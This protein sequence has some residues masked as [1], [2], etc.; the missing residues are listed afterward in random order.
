MEEMEDLPP[1][2]KAKKIGQIGP[3]KVEIKK[4]SKEELSR[5]AFEYKDVSSDEGQHY[6]Y[7]EDE[8]DPMAGLGDQM[9][10]DMEEAL[11][12]PVKPS[13]Q[14]NWLHGVL[15]FWGDRKSVV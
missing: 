15:G 11:L 6:K 8:E 3:S 1:P 5:N 14:F 12:R 4:P 13:G 7:Q 2:P 10:N 9:E